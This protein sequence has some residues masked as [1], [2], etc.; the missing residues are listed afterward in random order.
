M[1]KDLIQ[2]IA[3]AI[4]FTIFLILIFIITTISCSVLINRSIKEY[5]NQPTY[6]VYYEYN[7]INKDTI[8][9]DTIYIPIK[10]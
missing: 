2:T 9:I 1:F 10:H 5:R 6:K 7:V 4:A 8:P 3:I